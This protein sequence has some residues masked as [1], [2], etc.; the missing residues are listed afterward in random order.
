VPAHSA[1]PLDLDGVT[2]DF[3]RLNDQ[4]KDDRGNIATVSK[5]LA[6]VNCCYCQHV[7]VGNDFTDKRICRGYTE[8]EGGNND[9]FNKLLLR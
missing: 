1:R 3:V 7:T 9:D 8:R 4:P 2:E 6:F 5:L